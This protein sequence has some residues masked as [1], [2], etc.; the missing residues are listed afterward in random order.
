LFLDFH[1]IYHRVRVVLLLH[2]NSGTA[3]FQ[4]VILE[5]PLSFSYYSTRIVAKDFV[6]KNLDL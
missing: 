1:S 3:A 2:F 5:E 4:F 6:P